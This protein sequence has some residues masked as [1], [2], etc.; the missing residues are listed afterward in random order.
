MKAVLLTAAL[1]AATPAFAQEQG[2]HSGHGAMDHSSHGGMMH[3]TMPDQ[4]E[5]ESPPPAPSE[6]HS[7]HEA[8]E[9]ANHDGMM[10]AMSGH[11]E[12][13]PASPPPVPRDHAADALF[14][15]AAMARSRA[16]LVRETGA[17]N[18][19]M[20]L[21]DQLETQ[22][23]NGRDGY[24]WTGEAWFGSDIDRLTIKSEGE[25]TWRG[26]LDSAEVQALWSHAI[27]PWFNLQAGVRQDIRPTP[28]RSYAAVG[29]EGIA[30]YWFKVEATAFL[31]DKGDGFARLGASHDMRLTQRLILTPR[32]EINL[33]AQGK[34]VREA[35]FGA[36]LHYVIE[37]RFT[38]Y[39]GVEWRGVYGREAR[40]MRA[41]GDRPRATS[42]VAGMRFWF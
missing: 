13:M 32:A 14:D 8:P 35:E 36:R 11:E 9:H 40:E 34:A 38:P 28:A 20:I 19:S 16:M 18:H 10:P 42:F 5:T 33:A 4:S 23:R 17:M 31:S 15:P 2:E 30:P 29:L 37:P 22:V 21:I 39:V 1:L 24:R 12:A 27:D 7:G 25:G 3:D 41:E 6:D 26:R